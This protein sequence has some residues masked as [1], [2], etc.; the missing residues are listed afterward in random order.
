LF[1][2]FL[3][4]FV[5]PVFYLYMERFARGPENGPVRTASNLRGIDRQGAIRFDS[6]SDGGKVERIGG[7]KAIV[8]H[9]PA[10]KNGDIQIVSD[11]DVDMESGAMI[12]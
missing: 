6:L 7:Q 3:T 10:D 1:S 5:T 8:K 9:N 4:L 12:R 2:Q 11:W